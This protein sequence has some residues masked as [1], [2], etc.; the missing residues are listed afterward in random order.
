MITFICRMG[1]ISLDCLTELPTETKRQSLIKNQA[2]RIQNKSKAK[3][4]SRVEIRAQRGNDSQRYAEHFVSVIESFSSMLEMFLFLTVSIQYT[5]Q[6]Q[7]KGL[8]MYNGL[9]TMI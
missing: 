5:I 2:L 3:V 9:S 1:K 6:S 8:Y 7:P 4:E